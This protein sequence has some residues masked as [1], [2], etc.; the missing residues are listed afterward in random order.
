MLPLAERFFGKVLRFP[1]LCFSLFWLRTLVLFISRKPV[2][3]S[4]PDLRPVPFIG[5]IEEFPVDTS[6][7]GSS[8]F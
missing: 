4:M 2:T 3:L 6:L 8:A 1:L 7:V 5:L